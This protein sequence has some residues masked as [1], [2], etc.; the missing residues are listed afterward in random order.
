MLLVHGFSGSPYEMHLLAQALHQRGYHVAVPQLA[1]H[2]RSLR[3]LTASRY[4]DW[5]ASADA[6]LQTLWSRIAERAATPPRRC[7]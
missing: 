4:P 6:A 7:F 3:E 2:H 1:G 5:L